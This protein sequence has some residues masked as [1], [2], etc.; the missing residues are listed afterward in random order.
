[1]PFNGLTNRFSQSESRKQHLIKTNMLVALE[2]L[3]R[4][5]R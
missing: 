2:T 4:K 3:K 5:T 1:M